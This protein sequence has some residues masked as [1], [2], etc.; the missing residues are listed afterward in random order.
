MTAKDPTAPSSTVAAG[1]PTMTAV[2]RRAG[3]GLGTVSRVVNDSPHV[4]ESTRQR[5]L[6]ACTA[7]GYEPRQRRSD[8]TRADAG[9]HH[10]VAVLLPFFYEPSFVERLHGIVAQLATFGYDTVLHNVESPAHASEKLMELPRSRSVAGLIVVSLPVGAADAARLRAAAFPT[11]LVDTWHPELPSVRIDDR[12]GGSLAT[13]HLIDMG[14]ERIAFIGEPPHNAFGFTAGALREEG[15]RSTMARAGLA[16]PEEYVRYGAFLHS[17]AKNRATEL[18]SLEQPPTAIFAASDIQAVGCLEAARSMHLKV[19][20][21]LSVIGYDDVELAMLTGLTTIRQPLL[22]SGERGADLLLE[23][24]K[25]RQV[26]P[27]AEF[28]PLH[29]VVRDT[30]AVLRP[31]ARS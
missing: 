22:A 19:P 16:V 20:R 29:L 14:H 12:R 18:L 15:Y 13:Q 30:T 1:K 23:T 17:A 21:D 26:H 27:T 31:K 5:V 6:A 9:S 7:L 3:V 24:I 25:M 28:L 8:R 10:P 11:V 4:S 2:A